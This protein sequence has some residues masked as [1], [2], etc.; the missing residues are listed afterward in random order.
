M[1]SRGFHA[2]PEA[3]ETLTNE[4]WEVV[5]SVDLEDFMNAASPE[6]ET[7]KSRLKKTWEAGDFSQV[8]KHVESAAVEFVERL[9]FKPG[10]R[11][12]DV[13]CGSGNSAIAAARKGADVT[14]VDIASNLVEAARARAAAEG[15]KIHFDQGDAEDLPYEG[16]SFDVVIT[17]FGAMFAPR[18]EVVASELLRV[19]RPG[20]R[21]AMANWTP[22]GVPGQM[23]KL[24]AKYVPPPP[25]PPPVQ[26]GV[27]DIVRERFGDRV[28]DLKTEKRIANMVFEFPPAEV[29]EF[30][31]TYF[32]PTKMSFDSLD[33]DKQEEY[34]K[35]LEEHWA[36]YNLATDGTTRSESEYLEVVAIK[37]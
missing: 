10:D 27:E 8:A 9:G 5:K 1:A 29:V 15:L 30:F 23:F 31:R 16:E 25:M 13:A 2:R 24:N 28:V 11:V 26:W 19:T 6:M 34:R 22:E 17:M 36:K 33:P 7:L 12:L 14:G 3:A 18:P 21:I 20:G 32:G 4:Q 37:K 35:D